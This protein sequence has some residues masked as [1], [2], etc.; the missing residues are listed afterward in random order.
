MVGGLSLF[1]DH[2]RDFSDRYVL[3][4]GAACDIFMEEAGLEFRVTKDLDIVLCIEAY[5]QKFATKFQEFV[6]AGQ[7][8]VA[9]KAT[10]K[11]CFYRFEKPKE[12]NYPAMLELFSRVPDSIEI[13][14]NGHLTRL[15][16]DGEI[17][18]LSAI[19]LDDDYYRWILDG[20]R[21]IEGLS[22]IPPEYLIPLKAKAFLDLTR[23]RANGDS[24]QSNDI[25]KHKNDIFRLAELLRPGMMKSIP[26]HISVDMENFLGKVTGALTLKPATFEERRDRLREKY[27]T[28]G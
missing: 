16:M 3:I 27:T 11:K 12:T 10:G 13:S 14:P 17:A 2:F 15:A 1:R 9:E 19:L 18:S 23:Q 6:N 25:K 21:K 28:R 24:V 4:G 26:S 7:Y 20:K 8:Q 22:V 5:D